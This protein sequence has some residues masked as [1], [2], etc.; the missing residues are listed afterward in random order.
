MKTSQI[1]KPTSSRTPS[2]EPCP[3]GG[4][5]VSLTLLSTCGQGLRDYQRLH[6]ADGDTGAQWASLADA[7]HRQ[8]AELGLESVSCPPDSTAC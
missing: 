5:R 2:P 4:D 7:I 6:S 3:Q 1:V 8:E